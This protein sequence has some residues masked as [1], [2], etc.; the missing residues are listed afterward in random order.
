[1]TVSDR[2]RSPLTDCRVSVVVPCYNGEKYLSESLAS[3]L[4]QTFRDLEVIAV[5]D[6]SNDRSKEVVLAFEDQRVRLVEHDRN[7]GIAAARNTGVR[8]ARGEF[9]AFLDQDDLWYPEKLSK[10]VR[11]LDG[12]VDGDIALVFSNR[13]ILSQGKRFVNPEDRKFPH[14]INKVT[15][16]EVLK[17]FLRTN[18][19]PLISVVVR[20]GCFEKAGLFDETIR[21]GVDD[22]EFCV[23]LAMTGYRFAHIDEVLVTRREHE[24]NFSDPTQF[25]E[26]DLAVMARIVESDGTLEP[27][28]RQAHA[29]LLFQCGRWWHH[30]GQVDRER[31][32]YR[33]A[34]AVDP[35]NLKSRAALVLMHTG[36]LNDAAVGVWRFLR[37][38]KGRS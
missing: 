5:D 26:D 23:R 24:D 29:E 17:A 2:N 7:R 8:H 11:I 38:G 13:E 27:V 3:V 37:S 9:V 28:R 35:R 36:P 22:F 34:L 19:V 31:R 18:F 6:G 25:L 16:R 4:A 20:R 15:T 30:K 33:D 32:A 12:D 1:M 10:Q 21:S 14:P